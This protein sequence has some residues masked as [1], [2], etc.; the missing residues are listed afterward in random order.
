MTSFYNLCWSIPY[1]C[2]LYYA[3][4]S[5]R[6]MFCVSQPNLLA[7]KKRTCI[8]SSYISKENDHSVNFQWA[9]FPVE[10]SGVSAIVPS[11][12][13]SKMLIVKNQ[14]NETSTQLEIWSA[15]QM[16]KEIHVPKSIHGSVYTDAW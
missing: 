4:N 14:E 6:A 15:S 1:L 12:S 10:M 3:G 5:S 11:P 2:G 7:N 16:Q 9:P 8:L 13:A